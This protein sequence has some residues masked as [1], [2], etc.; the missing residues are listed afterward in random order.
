MA[1]EGKAQ[2]I[3]FDAEE[4]LQLELKKFLDSIRNRSKPLADGQVGLEALRIVEACYESSQKGQRVE[5]DWGKVL[6]EK[7]RKEL[8]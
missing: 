8:P 1:I 2:E 7:E 5:I 4:P 3:P 6:S